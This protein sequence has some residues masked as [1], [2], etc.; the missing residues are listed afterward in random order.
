MNP[1]K[2]INFESEGQREIGLLQERRTALISAAFTG[3]I[4]VRNQ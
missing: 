2:E 1:H 4:D 3:Q